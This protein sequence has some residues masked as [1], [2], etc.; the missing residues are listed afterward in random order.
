MGNIHKL[1]LGPG[2]NAK[3]NE[4][5]NKHVCVC[6]CVC[7]CLFGTWAQKPKMNQSTA[8]LLS[9]KSIGQVMSIPFS[10]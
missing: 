1:P 10:Q 8:H 3:D 9:P 2:N 4:V 5:A 6:M 7:V